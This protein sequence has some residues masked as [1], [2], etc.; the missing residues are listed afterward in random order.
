MSGWRGFGKELQLLL[1]PDQQYSHGDS[2]HNREEV[3]GKAQPLKGVEVVA[4]IHGP[5]T[6]AGVVG[7][8]L[9]AT[10]ERVKA[11]RKEVVP[12]Q[13]PPLA[14]RGDISRNISVIQNTPQNQA[15]SKTRLPLQFFPNQNISSDNRKL[16]T[17]LIISLNEGE[18]R[19]VSRRL[20]EEDKLPCAT[21]VPR[22]NNKTILTNGPG[23][24]LSTQVGS[25]QQATFEKGESSGV[26]RD[27]P[28]F[29]GLQLVEQSQPDELNPVKENNPVTFE[30][31]GSHEEIV[32]E[33][34]VVVRDPDW[35]VQLKDGR[36]LVLPDFIP[37]LWRK[38]TDP[39]SP[40]ELCL[41]VPAESMEMPFFGTLEAEVEVVEGVFEG[42][43]SD[44]V[45]LEVVSLPESDALVVQP[46]S[47]LGPPLADRTSSVEKPSIEFYQN[48]PSDWVL[49][50][51]KAIG[52]LVGASYEG[53]EDEVI[54][55]LQK[56]E[57]GRPQ[58]SDR[59]PKQA[60][61]SHSARG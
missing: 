32:R 29:S 40:M 22:V 56:I 14:S 61:G 7:R 23:H 13:P 37:S 4:G 26:L 20:K 12:P 46:L 45:G 16:G 42:L 24:D 25:P 15:Q 59:T 1:N 21:W 48:P 39:T 30:L 60:R 9:Q 10:L 38:L 34:G 36:R 53:Y 41:T 35:F 5:N 33:E 54:A 43:S 52:S 17:G 57:S 19:R 49:D 50:H 8:G 47:M 18:K 2:R 51:M 31:S 11:P 6:Y 28:N 3:G 58:A 55:L 44:S 27:G